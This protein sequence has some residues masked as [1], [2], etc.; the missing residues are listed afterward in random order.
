MQEKYVKDNYMA[1]NQERLG[2]NMY[3]FKNHM[4]EFEN[5][6]KSKAEEKVLKTKEKHGEERAK[7]EENII[8][9]ICNCIAPYVNRDLEV[10]WKTMSE[11]SN[12]MMD[13]AGSVTKYENGIGKIIAPIS[14]TEFHDRCVRRMVENEEQ[15]EIE[16]IGKPI[17]RCL[18]NDVLPF[19]GNNVP[20]FRRA[21]YDAKHSLRDEKT[22]KKLHEK[23]ILEAMRRRGEIS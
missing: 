12:A 16:E 15:R 19:V 17:C 5:R 6:C 1:I 21:I 4:P 10:V 3:I 18:T 22:I 11:V 14:K 8:K 2:I 23:M 7:I 9:P 20:I 13:A